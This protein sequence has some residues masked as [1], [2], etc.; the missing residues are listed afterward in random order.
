MGITNSNKE[1]S[2]P[3]ID[4]GGSFQVTFSLTAEPDIQSNPTDIV[5]ILDRSRSMAGSSLANLKNG[6]KRFIDII[7][8][9]TD[10][11]QDGQ[12][13]L[14]SRIGI[15]LTDQVFSCFKITSL[16]AP[17]KGTASLLNDT[18][19]E[20]KIG[21]LGEPVGRQIASKRHK[22]PSIH[23]VLPQSMPPK[24]KRFER[25]EKAHPKRMCLFA[26]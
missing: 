16:S 21:E 13:G 5:L 25:E 23:S 9:A 22:C 24:S 11:A 6:A 2:V 7:D 1:L 10:G 3:R 12:I 19:V 15:V 17:T 18:T 20:W 8:E 4:C 26:L 14:G